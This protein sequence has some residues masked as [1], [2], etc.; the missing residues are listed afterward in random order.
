MTEEIIKPNIEEIAENDGEVD[1]RL[2]TDTNG[3]IIQLDDLLMPSFSECNYCPIKNKCPVFKEDSHCRIE[4]AMVVESVKNLTISQ[5]QDV[6]TKFKLTMFDFLVQLVLQFRLQIVGSRIDYNR[7]TD[8]KMADLLN[9][10]VS[11]TAS[12]SRR[13]MEGLKE[14]SATPREQLK[15]K[16]N[17]KASGYIVYAEQMERAK[18][19]E[20]K[21]TD[22]EEDD[23]ITD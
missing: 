7:L 23:V 9:K 22:G 21:L 19:E 18:A 20:K 13:Y 8:P 1:T 5:N 14:L 16:R 6:T 2:F 11:M 12:V 4:E 17:Q 15:G 10:Y 3:N